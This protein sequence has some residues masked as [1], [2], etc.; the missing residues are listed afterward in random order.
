MRRKIIGDVR[1]DMFAFMDKGGYEVIP[2]VS[3]KFMVDVGRPSAEFT[4]ALQKEVMSN[5]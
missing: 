3:N 1:N 5:A 2:S 4:M